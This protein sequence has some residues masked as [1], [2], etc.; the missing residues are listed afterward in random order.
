MQT[1]TLPDGC[2]LKTVNVNRDTC[3]VGII[4]AESFLYTRNLSAKYKLEDLQ[5][6]TFVKAEIAAKRLAIMPIISEVLNNNSTGIST[7]TTGYG[8]NIIVDTQANHSY[9]FNIPE[10]SSCT[11]QKLQ[12]ITN[13]PVQSWA[14][15]KNRIAGTPATD[16]TDVY[17]IGQKSTFGVAKGFMFK[18]SNTDIQNIPM[19]YIANDSRVEH[20]AE[21]SYDL[22]GV[23]GLIDSTLSITASSG[24]SVTVSVL[25]GCQKTPLSGLVVADFEVL[26]S[27]GVAVPITS[28]TEISTGVY[29]LVPTTSPF[30]AGDY[31]VNLDGVVALAGEQYIGMDVPPTFT[32][33]P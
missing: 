4:K 25:A 22:L 32:V 33:A 19:T 27:L 16:G 15:S 28:A 8:R 6:E 21:T 17:F 18:E 13:V 14:I 1:I 9:E 30:P 3:F 24:T 20:F 12:Q 11:F 26:T 2:V 10:I 7:A 23:N 29:T 31:S 5:N